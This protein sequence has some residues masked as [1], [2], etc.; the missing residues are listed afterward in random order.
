M[1][2]RQEALLKKLLAK[3]TK[4]KQMCNLYYV[5]FNDLHYVSIKLVKKPLYM[6]FIVRHQK[7]TRTV[8]RQCFNGFSPIFKVYTGQLAAP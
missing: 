8:L 7:I 3:R 6:C 5:H 2:I 4:Q 1:F